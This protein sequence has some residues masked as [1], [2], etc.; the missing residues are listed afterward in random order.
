[1][2]KLCNVN[3]NSVVIDNA[4]ERYVEILDIIKGNKEHN[5]YKDNIIRDKINTNYDSF[6]YSGHI[7][8]DTIP[9]EE[10]FKKTVSQYLSWKISAMMSNT[11]NVN[12]DV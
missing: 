10:D 6:N 9:T 2:C 3:E 5:Y 4:E 8:I 12:K 11:Y 1:M 7:K